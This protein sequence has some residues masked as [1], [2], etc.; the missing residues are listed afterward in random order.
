MEES[1]HDGKSDAVLTKDIS[2]VRRVFGPGRC[3]I[4]MGPSGS[5]KSTKAA[6][7]AAE[8]GA[9]VVSYD[10]H[11]RRAEGDTGVEPVGEQALARAW[12]ELDAHLAAGTLVVVD[13][14]H[15]Q[16]ERRAAVREIAAAHGGAPCAAR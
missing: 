4:V 3:L 1:R 6:Q 5:G 15:C 14:T 10:D 2:A 7:L 16:P 9:V 11:Q 12:A 8:L 13:G